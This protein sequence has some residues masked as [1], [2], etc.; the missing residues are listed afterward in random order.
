[1][2]QTRGFAVMTLRRKLPSERA[3][4]RYFKRMLDKYFR[5][6]AD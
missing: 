3:S 2:L 6:I 1:M 5:R 4:P